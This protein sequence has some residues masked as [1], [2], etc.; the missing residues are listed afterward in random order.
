VQSTPS[1]R[2]LEPGG[3][4]DSRELSR[5]ECLELLAANSLGR[6]A[7]VIGDRVPLIR[8]VNYAYDRRSQ[9]V[10]FRTAEGSKLHAL[11]RA[12][13]AAFEIDG[14]DE[15]AATA[16]SVIITGVT[17]EITDASE[18]RRLH[19]LGLMSWAPGPKPHWLRIR[20]GTVSG[21]RISL[22]GEPNASRPALD[23]Q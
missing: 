13:N 2:R 3:A 4:T 9:S 15:A 18:L 6:M 8:P 22:A 23:I 11:W 17:T 14:I 20:A 16:W 21:R 5:D 12:T 7:V 19:R 10:V 1:S